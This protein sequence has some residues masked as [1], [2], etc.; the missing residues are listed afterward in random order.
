MPPAEGGLRQ[1][2]RWGRSRVPAEREREAWSRKGRSRDPEAQE[3]S[4]AQCEE[5]M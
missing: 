5:I 2:S 3:P 1:G 4:P